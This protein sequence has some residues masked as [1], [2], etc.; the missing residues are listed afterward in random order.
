MRRVAWRRGC[1]RRSEAANAEAAANVVAETPAASPCQEL[2]STEDDG[3]RVTLAVSHTFSE[4]LQKLRAFEALVAKG[5]HEKAAVVAADVQQLISQF[6]PRM[7][8]PELF[9]EFA[10][11]MSDNVNTISAHMEQ[12][13]LSR[14]ECA[15]SILPR[16]PEELCRALRA[17]GVVGVP[18]ITLPPGMPTHEDLEAKVDA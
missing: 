15:R 6:D 9:S 13:W 17:D 3:R 5:R 4:L 16:R 18:A 11:L 7:Y 10:A 12:P 14:L 2:R 8:F 1:E